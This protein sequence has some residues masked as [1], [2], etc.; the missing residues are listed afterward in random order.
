[1]KT[2]L[3]IIAGLLVIVFAVMITPV[4]AVGPQQVSAGATDQASVTFTVTNTTSSLTFGSGIFNLNANNTIS[5]SNPDE[6][7]KF[8]VVQVQTNEATWY[9]TAVDSAN[10]GHMKSG[11]FT[12]TNVTGIQAENVDGA[13]AA[14]SV[15]NL[16]PLSGSAQPILT[17]S[18]VVPSITDIASLKIDQYVSTGDIAAD[19]YAITIILA[20]ENTLT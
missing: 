1:M 10:N 20:Y 12:L 4:L 5:K 3:L 13:Y 14:R 17:G 15:A 7:G 19:N 2:K 11:S 16:V 9:I 18:G 6:S 8:P